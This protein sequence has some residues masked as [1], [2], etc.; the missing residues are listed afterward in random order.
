MRRAA[1]GL[2]IALAVGSPLAASAD[3]HSEVDPTTTDSEL[4][5]YYERG[6]LDGFGA[7]IADALEL[8]LEAIAAETERLITAAYREGLAAGRAETG[9]GREPNCWEDEVRVV[10]YS[11]P[12]GESVGASL[13][14][15]VGCVA[16]DNLPVS[17][18]R[19]EGDDPI[20][21]DPGV[22]IR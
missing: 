14:G 19:P 3:D 1:I 21:I 10:V 11:D 4:S 12:I 5:L 22:G 6:F 18:Y 2:A 7:A 17:G 15:L 20:Y 13:V 16:A 8:E 9:R